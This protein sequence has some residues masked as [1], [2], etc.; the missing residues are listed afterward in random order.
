MTMCTK[1]KALIAVNAV[2]FVHVLHNTMVVLKP[3]LSIKKY[4][5]SSLNLRRTSS[6]VKLRKKCKKANLT[7]SLELRMPTPFPR[8]LQCNKD[9]LMKVRHQLPPEKCTGHPWYQKCSITTATK[10][11]MATWLDYH[12]ME[13]QKRY[14]G[15]I[16]DTEDEP[17]VPSFLGITI[18]CNKGFDAINTLRTGTYDASINKT[19]WKNAMEQDTNELSKSVCKQDTSPMFEVIEE[20][21]SSSSTSLHRKPHGEMHCIELMPQTYERLRVS[22]ETLGYDKKGLKVVNA[23][24]SKETGEQYI[25]SGLSSG[26]ENHGLGACE[27]MDEDKRKANCQRVQV[28]S[29]SDYIEA[30][31]KADNEDP[32]NILSIDVEGFDG[33][34]LLGATAKV[35]KRVEYLEFEYNWMGAWQD[36][37]LF[38]I[39]QMLDETAD[40][41]CYWTGIDQLWRV[42]DCWM[43]YF[44]LHFWSNIGC[45]N[46]RLVPDLAAKM[47]EWFLRTLNNQKQWI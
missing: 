38:D 45:V 10:C 14:I 24:V 37:H 15:S 41:T 39:I 9:Q 30:H 18:G 21:S 12:Y 34:V 29:L 3:Q 31:V 26:V 11:P 33:D 13:L 40:L 43:S 22:A 5:P 8:P 25:E 17:H 4:L 23:A 44:D 1:Y 2:V 7:S 16:Q 32:I 35:L 36:Q 47:E 28:Y 27:D 6:E 19:D 42:T 20:S 46:R